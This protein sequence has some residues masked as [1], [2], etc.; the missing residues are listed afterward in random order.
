MTVGVTWPCIPNPSIL[1]HRVPG[2]RWESL[3]TPGFSPLPMH[4]GD[5]EAPEG[6]GL[7]SLGPT[8]SSDPIF[9]VASRILLT[10]PTPP[11]HPPVLGSGFSTPG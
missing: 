2:G 3:E 7:L 11:A 6:R 5:S 1:T 4:L 9:P 10:S 8:H